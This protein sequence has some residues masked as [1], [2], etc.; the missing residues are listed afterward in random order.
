MVKTKKGP[1][2]QTDEISSSGKQKKISATPHYEGERGG[3]GRAGR[4]KPEAAK[5]RAS[6]KDLPVGRQGG[7]EYWPTSYAEGDERSI[8]NR[9]EDW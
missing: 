2:L 6:K 8:K 9:R 5:D 1:K 7:E 4:Y 3:R